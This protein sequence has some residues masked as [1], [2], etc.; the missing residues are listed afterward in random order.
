M[1][2]NPLTWKGTET[3]VM[4]SL[5]FILKMVRCC[6]LVYWCHFYQ[7]CGI[8]KEKIRAWKH[9]K[10]LPVWEGQMFFRP[11]ERE[12]KE[13]KEGAWKKEWRVRKIKLEREL[14]EASGEERQ[15]QQP[16]ANPE[17]LGV[18][19]PWENKKSVSGLCQSH[20]G[21]SHRQREQ[22]SH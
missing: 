13:K 22:M 5:L 21:I 14:E 2:K 6:L 17:S 7:I 19:S 15:L 4:T 1:E 18:S 10:G 20:T 11:T 9:E 16:P 8:E 12:K 3:T